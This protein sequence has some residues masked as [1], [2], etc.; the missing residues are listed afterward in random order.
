MSSLAIVV[1]AAVVGDGCV[2]RLARPPRLVDAF[3]CSRKV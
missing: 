2:V 3:V 1:N